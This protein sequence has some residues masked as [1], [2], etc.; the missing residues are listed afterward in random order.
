[1]LVEPEVQKIDPVAK[2]GDRDEGG[3]K[4]QTHNWSHRSE[5]CDTRQRR[6]SQ[7]PIRTRFDWES[8]SDEDDDD[9]AEQ[10]SDRATAVG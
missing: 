7:M 9:N 2:A 5:P 10:R 4:P 1:V 6:D 3:S 8:S